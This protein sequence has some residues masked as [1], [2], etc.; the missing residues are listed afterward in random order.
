MALTLTTVTIA[1]VSKDAVEVTPAPSKTVILDEV[2][3]EVDY[4]YLNLADAKTG[5]NL[6][7]KLKAVTLPNGVNGFVLYEKMII[8]PVEYSA[9][10]EAN[11]LRLDPAAAIATLQE[12]VADHELR[13]VALETAP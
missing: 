13:I 1:G 12:D 5:T 2:L 4:K 10:V 9:K 7:E 6:L 3:Q 8:D 11:K